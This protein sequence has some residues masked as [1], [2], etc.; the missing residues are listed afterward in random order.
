MANKEFQR[1]KTILVPTDIFSQLLYTHVFSSL[2]SIL[3]N[4]D[5][6][7]PSKVFH[8]YIKKQHLWN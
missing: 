4:I 2:T 3:F 6:S 5:L 1:N 8:C 7:S